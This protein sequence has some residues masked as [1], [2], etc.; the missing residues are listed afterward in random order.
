MLLP[1]CTQYLNAEGF[2]TDLKEKKREYLKSVIADMAMQGNRTL[3]LSYAERDSDEF[4]AQEP[5]EDNL[6]LI[7]LVGIQDPIRPEVPAAVAQCQKAGIIVRMVTGDNKQTAVSIAEKCGIYQHGHGI[8]MEGKEFRKM[9]AEKPAE[10]RA[11]LPKLQILARSS[12]SDKNVLVDVIHKVG[13]VVAVTGDGTN[14]A[15]ALKMADVGFAMKSGTDIARNASDM[16]ILDDNFVSVVKATMWGRN[17]N[18]NIRK[19]LQF[20]VTVNIVGV[21]LTFIG[22]AFSAAN[23]SPLTSVQLLWLNLIM[24]TLAALAL[25]TEQ[26]SEEVL[27]RPPRPKSAPLIS[28]RMWL[29]IAGQG[30][31]ML[32]SMSLL[33]NSGAEYLGLE[34]NG[35]THLTLVFNAFIMMQIFNEFNARKLYNEVNVFSGMLTKSLGHLGITVIM[36]GFQFFAVQFAGDWMNTVPLSVELWLVSVLIGAL[37]L[38]LSFLLRLIPVSEPDAATNPNLDIPDMLRKDSSKLKVAADQTVSTIRVAKALTEHKQDSASK[39]IRSRGSSI[40]MRKAAPLSA[41]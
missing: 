33:L 36:V 39:V 18:D 2:R 25:A 41:I 5:Q 3:L 20:Q 31:F 16:I 32:V 6:C 4:P 40:H 30:V 34:E 14:D 13:E 19:F 15:P 12:P 17:V 23:K 1:Q 27:N 37:T 28:R 29:N 8:A 35:K 24:D 10:L 9:A 26:P 11:I 22:A 38:P 7:C 21:L